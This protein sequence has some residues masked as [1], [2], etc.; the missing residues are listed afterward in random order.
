MTFLPSYIRQLYQKNVTRKRKI[1]SDKKIAACIV[2]DSRIILFLEKTTEF[3]DEDFDKSLNQSDA[4][5]NEGHL[6]FGLGFGL[7][8]K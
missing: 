5:F 4:L 6:L 3:I 1:F 7:G 2:A 8:Y